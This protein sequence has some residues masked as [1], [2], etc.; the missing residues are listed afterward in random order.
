MTEKQ[1]CLWIKDK[2]C[3]QNYNTFSKIHEKN[4]DG[5]DCRESV[6]KFCLIANLI[7]TIQEC[8]EKIV[9]K[10]DNND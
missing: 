1:N 8:T 5:I 7:Q 2:K 9:R 10:S 4:K 3:L 6:C